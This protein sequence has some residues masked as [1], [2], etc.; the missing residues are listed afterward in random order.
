MKMLAA[1]VAVLM[2]SEAT[3][4]AQEVAT[5]SVMDV[6]ISTES[7]LYRFDLSADGTL[8]G[9][10]GKYPDY[11]VHF[12]CTTPGSSGRTELG[13]FSTGDPYYFWV[14]N[15]VF[16]NGQSGTYTFGCEVRTPSNS[17]NLMIRRDDITTVVSTGSEQ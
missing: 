4:Q 8:D 9:F 7:G 13:T 14:E 17:T 15:E 6:T 12:Y 1:V 3:A 2:M 16:L 5:V 11:E 10:D